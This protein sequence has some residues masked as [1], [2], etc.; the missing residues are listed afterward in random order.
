M[1]NIL[2]VHAKQA[3]NEE[4][5]RLCEGVK[6]REARLCKASENATRRFQFRKNG[7][8]VSNSAGRRAKRR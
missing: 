1:C 3:L 6:V 4:L 8:S 5:A 2:N 7:G